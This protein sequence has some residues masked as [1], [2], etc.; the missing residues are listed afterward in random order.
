MD[1][2]SARSARHAVHL[3]RAPNESSPIPCGSG[4]RTQPGADLRTG[5]NRALFRSQRRRRSLLQSKRAPSPLA[6]G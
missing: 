1:V 6:P 3:L 2:E 4:D 5:P